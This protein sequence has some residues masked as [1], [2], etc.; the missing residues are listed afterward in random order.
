MVG[1]QLVPKPFQPG[2]QHCRGNQ[3]EGV[4]HQVAYF[5]D[6]KTQT[7]A[8]RFP[9]CHL[10]PRSM[11]VEYADIEVTLTIDRRI[12]INRAQSDINVCPTES[13]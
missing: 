8:G 6:H 1:A 3:P 11:A 7:L 4:F 12:S 13:I 2:S 9:K 5:R 10:Q